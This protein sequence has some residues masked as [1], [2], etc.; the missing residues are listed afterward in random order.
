[1][2]HG[3]SPGQSALPLAAPGGSA[4]E[5]PEVNAL[6]ARRLF[7]RDTYEPAR[8]SRA[9]TAD[10][11]GDH[12]ELAGKPALVSLAHAIRLFEQEG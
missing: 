3:K 6:V 1:M 12:A 5:L 9:L 8:K 10:E 11:A 7:A 2:I 4:A